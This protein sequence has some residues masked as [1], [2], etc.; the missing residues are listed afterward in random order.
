MFYDERAIRGNR[1]QFGSAQ[2]AAKYSTILLCRV[3]PAW[4]NISKP[5]II[6]VRVMHAIGTV[7]SLGA[8]S[9]CM[10]GKMFTISQKDCTV[11]SSGR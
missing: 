1:L 10:K 3:S 4:Q 5:K 9:K 8:R 2:L 7:S 11:Y 6:A